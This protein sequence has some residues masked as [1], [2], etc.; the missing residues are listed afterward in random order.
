MCSSLL[1]VYEGYEENP[2]AHPPSMDMDDWLEAPKSATLQTTGVF[3]YHPENSIDEDDIEDDEAGHEAGDELEPHDTDEDLQLV[4]AVDSGNAS[5]TNSS[6]GADGCNYDADASNDSNS[7]LNLAT[8]RHLHKR[9]F[10]EAAARGVKQTTNSSTTTTDEEEEEEEDENKT[11][12]SHLSTM[13]PPRSC[14]VLPTK[15]VA[16]VKG[17]ANNATPAF[18]PISEET[19][20]LDPEPALPSVTT[21][22]PHSGDSWMNYS[23]NSSDD[24]SGL[25]EQIKAVASG[26]QTCKK[27]I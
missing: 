1:I 27:S 23:S 16:G 7:R 2:M 18:I 15:S 8:R 6:T 11:Q 10:A 17:I 5:A 3:D 4:A 22:S 21:S 26:R 12:H 20:F 14:G 13:P 19:V 24:F 9:G 25:S